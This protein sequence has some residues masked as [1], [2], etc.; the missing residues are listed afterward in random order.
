MTVKLIQSKKRNGRIVKAE[1]KA[2]LKEG[3]YKLR[4]VGKAESGF[5]LAAEVGDDILAFGFVFT[6]QGDAVEFGEKMYGQKGVKFAPNNSRKKTSEV[7][8]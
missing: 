4:I 6:K 7:A 3:K 2:G 5:R 8:A 1:L